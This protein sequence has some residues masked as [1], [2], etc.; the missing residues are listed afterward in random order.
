MSDITRISSLRYPTRLGAMYER[1]LGALGTPEFGPTVRECV[2]GATGGAHRLYLF[3]A[4]GRVDT[5]LQYFCGEPG[6]SDLFPDYRRW[7]LRQDPVFE[8]CRAAPR[9]NDVALQRVRPRHIASTGFRRRVFE[10]AGIVERVSVIQRGPAGWRVLSIARHHSQ[11]CCSDAEIESLV[12]LACLVLPM[13]PLNRERV[14]L[15]A[16]PDVA[17][18]ELRF[19]TRF[20]ALTPRE[21]A[22]CAR[23][24]AGRGVDETAA[25]LGIGRASVLTYRKR[26]YR[27]LGVAGACALRA[28]VTN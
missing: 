18:L 5:S 11:G 17:Q 22:V 9:C 25:E 12:G 24:A 16:P 20:A 1:M 8:A 14:P 15:A 3:E 10:E 4:A 13:L 26:A 7:Y 6:L 21:R 27:R 23:A 2:L 19:A 28:L